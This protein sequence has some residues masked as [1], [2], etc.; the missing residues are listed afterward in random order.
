MKLRGLKYLIAA[1]IVCFICA[2]ADAQVCMN[3]P[4]LGAATAWLTTRP[5]PFDGFGFRYATV[6]YASGS[7]APSQQV[8]TVLE[9]A[10]FE[11]NLQACRTGII[12]IPVP[13]AGD[14]K[15][16]RQTTE[17]LT[18]G[19]ANYS[20][21]NA[22]IRYGPAFLNRL[23]SLGSVQARVV[24]LHEIGHFFG[25]EEDTVAPP[26]IMTQGTSCSAPASVTS[27]SSADG[28]T[29]A[30]C[31]NSGTPC[32]FWF[33][34]PPIG[35]FECEQGGGYWNFTFGGCFPEPQ[36][37]PCVD[38]FSN[39]DC[40]NGDVCHDG[41]CGPPEFVCI[42]ECPWDTVC[43]EGLCSYAT[44][45]L[46]DVDGNGFNMTN[47][48][49]G[50][51]FDFDGDGQRQR[52]PWT[53]AGSD[54]AWLVMDLNRN[55]LIDSGREMFGNV[56]NQPRIAGKERNG[57]I[58]LSEFDTSG[59]GGNGDG[60]ISPKDYFFRS[61]R[62]WTDANHNGI[63]EATE[64]SSLDQ[65]GIDVVELE[66]KLSSRSDRNGNLFRYRAK[67]KNAMGA[68][69]GRWAWDV[70]FNGRGK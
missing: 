31:L 37:T 40:C 60:V 21:A 62:L 17:T 5:H 9:D 18:G 69:L 57:F 54:D 7:N 35:P 58:A 25:L 49:Q 39:G 6:T 47:T 56:S 45:I 59:R 1:C 43:V 28:T 12:L 70:I 3:Q 27:V 8:L 22:E 2:T 20:F 24:M 30:G 11:W 52:L 16:S 14:L 10:V 29:V 41:V 32:Q 61:L 50:V 42:P 36:T 13:A 38:C 64:L 65:T 55:G 46:I 23:A 34:F 67:V 4:D 68:Q 51:E 66:Y 26:S 33:F 15:F 48:A 19:C 53:A 44:P 63:S